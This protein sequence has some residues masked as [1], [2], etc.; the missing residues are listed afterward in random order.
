[1]SQKTS[2]TPTEGVSRILAGKL[3]SLAWGQG[4]LVMNA[5]SATPELSV[6]PTASHFTSL[7]P[8]FPC[9]MRTLSAIVA[10]PGSLEGG[11]FFFLCQEQGL[12]QR[13]GQSVHTAQQFAIP[14]EISVVHITLPTGPFISLIDFQSR[15]AGP[16][17]A[18]FQTVN[19]QCQ[20][21]IRRR[22]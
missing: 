21:I 20:M 22:L 5:G 11:M 2:P 12:A 13:E 18:G 9:G 10:F 19:K 16:S 17:S 6:R 7:R 1:M 14:A 8:S 15:V 4:E 3:S